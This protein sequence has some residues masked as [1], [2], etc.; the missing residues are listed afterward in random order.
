MH[1]NYASALHFYA[2]LSRLVMIHWYEESNSSTSIP[3]QRMVSLSLLLQ[4]GCDDVAE[5]GVQSGHRLYDLAG[6]AGL[7]SR[8]TNTSLVAHRLQELICL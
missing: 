2:A 8:V 6:V 3:L 4:G 5:S 1:F 7:W